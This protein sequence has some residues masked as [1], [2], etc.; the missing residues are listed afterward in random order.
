MLTMTSTLDRAARMFGARPAIADAHASASWAEHMDRVRR[1]AA[2]LRSHGLKPGERFAVMGLNSHLYSEILHAG[3]WA[4]LIPV[5]INHRLAP[6]EIRQIV[7]DAGCKLLAHCNAFAKVLATPELS[8]LKLQPLNLESDYERR[9]IHSEP[10]PAHD[11]RPEALALLLFTGGTT[12]RSK[13]VCLSHANIVSNAMQVA[14]A[15]RA[16]PQD[17]FLHA[18]PMFHAADL[19]A[20]AFTLVGGSHAYLPSFSGDGALAAMRDRKVSVAMLAPTMIV[21][22]LQQPDVAAYDLSSLRLIFYGSSPIDAV[23]V[24]RAMAAFPNVDLQHNYGCTETSPILT[25]VEPAEVRERFSAGDETILRSAGRAVA[26]VD[27]TIRDDRGNEL[28]QGEVGEVVVRGPNVASGYFNRPEETE[29]AFRDGWFHTGDMGRLDENGLLFIV[30]RKKDMVITGGEN[31][32]TSEV[33]AALYLHPHVQ[34]AAVIGVPDEKYGEA[35]FAVIVPVQGKDVSVDDIVE[36]CRGRIGAYK[37]PRRGDIV[38][39]LPKSAM[40][41]IL[42]NELRRIYAGRETKF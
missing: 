13:G 32:Y 36:H 16:G 5:P 35:L 27:L 17:R 30:D 41:K 19:L 33:E 24:R 42:K 31:V 26:G 29:A 39:E 4:G 22:I 12:G 37:I 21:M 28:A 11:A 34:E 8:A 18:A 1:A 7:G 25:A 10:V 20:N 14:L 6:P 2:V 23:W 38:T 15:M 40:G 9:L 3:Y